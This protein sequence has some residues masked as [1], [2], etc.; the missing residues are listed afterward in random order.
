MRGREGRW[1]GGRGGCEEVESTHTLV[2]QQSNKI[3]GMAFDQLSSLASFFF[4]PH[5]LLATLRPHTPTLLQKQRGERNER[6][7][8]D[9]ATEAM[10][11]PL[12]SCSICIVA[13]PLAAQTTPS[14]RRPFPRSPHFLCRTLKAG[15]EAR[16]QHIKGLA[17][18]LL[19]TRPWCA[20]PGLL[21]PPTSS[22]LLALP[23]PLI[24]QHCHAQ[25]P[26]LPPIHSNVG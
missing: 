22:I 20:L 9:E 24:R 21:L 12:W 17:L 5:L 13:F 14:R 6:V 2:S 19:W 23:C 26:F 1:E 8:D 7:F 15:T 16:A 10:G 3:I 25:R 11:R 18:C 4:H